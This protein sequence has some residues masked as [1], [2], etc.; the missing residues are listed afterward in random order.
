MYWGATPVGRTGYL[1]ARL[2][3][4]SVA[5]LAAGLLCARI[6]GLGRIDA[7]RELGV[8]CIGALQAPFFALFLAAFAADKVEGLS[9]LKALG[10]LDI[11][12]LAIY[13]KLPARLVAWPFP[14]YWA[15]ELAIGTRF[16]SVLAL[17]VGLLA[18]ALWIAALFAKYRKRID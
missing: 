5:S 12:P 4:F 6:L 3:L 11:A 8:A 16:T 14:Q 17:A 2:G 10:G 7:G 15:A 18:S 13:L 9:I 1:A